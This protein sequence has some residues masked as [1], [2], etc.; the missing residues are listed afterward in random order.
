[1]KKF[2]LLFLI[3][4]SWVF[5]FPQ[6]TS[7]LQTDGCGLPD[8]SPRCY[9]GCGDNYCESEE[10]DTCA[11]W[12]LSCSAGCTGQTRWYE[13]EPCGGDD[14]PPPPTLTPSPTITP[15]PSPTPTLPAWMMTQGGD[16]FTQAG[17]SFGG[18]FMQNI[19][20][21]ITIT[22]SN[23]NTYSGLNLN[24]NFPYFASYNYLQANQVPSCNNCSG[25][26]Y[27][28][29]SPGGI[30]KNYFNSTSDYSDTNNT[31]VNGRYDEIKLLLAK[32]DFIDKSYATIQEVNNLNLALN[33]NGPEFPG[34][35][36]T[37]SNLLIDSD[38]NGF[39]IVDVQGNLTIGRNHQ[40]DQK[41]IFLIK[42]DLRINPN[43]TTGSFNSGCLFAVGNKIIIEKGSA[44]TTAGD[45]PNVKF[46]NVNGY[47]ITNDFTTS[48][49]CL[50]T[51]EICDGLIINGGIVTKTN[52]FARKISANRLSP[53]EL[54]IF[55][56]RYLMLFG[57][58]LDEPID[59][60]LVEKQ[61][62][63]SLFN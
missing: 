20:V 53:S 7:A 37:I 16:V 25:I 62:L 61:Y 43:L 46:D 48:I 17:V 5:L 13:C 34:T 9:S 8:C 44:K 38:T 30:P 60:T 51:P 14:D 10:N 19:L 58:I 3:L 55:D 28:G 2:I 22:N 57:K 11:A 33:I 49:D 56:N 12:G 4:I 54:V 63:E 59:F 45:L 32:S 41:I 6:K 36:L 18:L 21:K 23:I 50:G 52:T 24:N 31:P 26:S 39:F 47:F 35:P 1:M 27:Q 42:D 40:C 15:S 29:A